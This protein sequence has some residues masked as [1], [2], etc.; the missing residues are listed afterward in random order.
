MGTAR[1]EDRL[2][3]VFITTEYIDLFDVGGYIRDHAN[4]LPDGKILAC[5]DTREYQGR[6][7][8]ALVAKTLTDDGGAPVEI[9]EYVFEGLK[10]IAYFSYE[11]SGEGEG[12]PY[13]ASSSDEAISD[14]HINISRG[15]EASSRVMEGTIYVLPSGADIYYINPVYQSDDGSVYLTPGNGISASGEH[16]EGSIM[17]QTLEN[18]YR[19]AENG[20]T[21]TDKFSVNISVSVMLAPEKIAVLSMDSDSNTI[22][23][24]EYAP[25][26]LP[27]TFV[28]E[29][30]ADYLVVETRKTD[31]RGN[32]RVSREIY[33]NG[34]E[35]MATFF[36]REDGVCIK[37]ETEIQWQSE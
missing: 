12:E 17:A 2:S 5:G 35:N 24:A 27:K 30:N 18:T 23:R 4:N 33:D 7:Y 32:Y 36:A 37:R 25:N 9:K 13:T 26:A 14:G 3:G 15:D 16:D 11:I 6:V 31:A 20:K 22:A 34:A 1:N 10:G 21:K 19:T 8:A 29:K 28:A